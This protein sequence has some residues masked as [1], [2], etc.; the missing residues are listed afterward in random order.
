MN[1]IKEK[2]KSPVA[3]GCLVAYIVGIMALYNVD[4]ASHTEYILKGLITVF[5]AFGVFNNP[6][7]REGF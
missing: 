1:D 7:D 2:M 4:M 3:W 6:N 5:V